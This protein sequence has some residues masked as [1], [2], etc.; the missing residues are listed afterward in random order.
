[1]VFENSKIK[2]IKLA[3]T[4]FWYIIMPIC[5]FYI[6]FNKPIL[7]VFW[8]HK[9]MIFIA[10][11]AF[12]N[13]VMDSIENEGIFLTVF[14]KFKDKFWYKRVSWKYS[15]KIYQYKLDA[16]HISKSLMIISMCLSAIFYSVSFNILV[17]FLLMGFIW[18]HTFNGFYKHLFKI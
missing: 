15:L 16:W 8:E 6:L 14:S 18:N 5:L 9:W 4:Y 13:S 7:N 2:S 11:S 17:D 1:M 3:F 12:F 10:L